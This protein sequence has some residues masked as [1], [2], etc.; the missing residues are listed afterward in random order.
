MKGSYI[1]L[2]AATFHNEWDKVKI[3]IATTCIPKKLEPI[4]SGVANGVL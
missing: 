1:S 2:E 3:S 4:L